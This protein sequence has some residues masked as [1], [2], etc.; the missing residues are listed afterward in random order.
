MFEVDTGQSFA[1][2]RRL[3]RLILACAAALF[4]LL[5]ACSGTPYWGGS[6]E[7]SLGRVAVTMTTTGYIY[8]VG[9]NARAN[10][11]EGARVPPRNGKDDREAYEAHLAFLSSLALD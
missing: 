5:P 7:L 3:A 9:P 8:L 2:R 4:A 10:L 1:S 11:D 6:P